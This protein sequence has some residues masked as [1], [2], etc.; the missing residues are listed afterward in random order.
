MTIPFHCIACGKSANV[1]DHFGGKNVKCKCGHV[2][3]V[4]SPEID[5][6]RVQFTAVQDPRQKAQP[7]ATHGQPKLSKKEREEKLLA[8]Q[9]GED[10]KNPKPQYHQVA[11]ER[12]HWMIEVWYAMQCS[13]LIAAAVFLGGIILICLGVLAFDSLAAQA[14]ETQTFSRRRNRGFMLGPLLIGMGT[15]GACA[16]LFVIIKGFGAPEMKD[17]PKSKSA[18]VI[19]IMVFAALLMAGFILFR[20]FT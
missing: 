2:V 3:A 1:P 20:A 5:L 6:N 8:E 16:S 10:W 11:H 13:P 14:E 15:L 18:L 19:G 9:L 4:A 12:E 7:A 17:Y